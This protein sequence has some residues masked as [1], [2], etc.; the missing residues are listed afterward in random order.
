MLTI[1]GGIILAALLLPVVIILLGLLWPLILG[2]VTF[3][4]VWAAFLIGL[5][6]T[7]Q[8]ATFWGGVAGVCVT[9]WG[10]SL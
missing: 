8:F 4:V 6:Q 9:C 7:P 3:A 10:Y 2:I 5:D 1:A